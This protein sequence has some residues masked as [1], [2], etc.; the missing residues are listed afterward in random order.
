MGRGGNEYIPKAYL[1]QT[2]DKKKVILE[3]R[4]IFGNLHSE[5]TGEPVKTVLHKDQV[6]ESWVK[7][8]QTILIKKWYKSG[9]LKEEGYYLNDQLHRA[10]GPALR[11]WR[12]DGQ[13]KLEAFYLY[14]EIADNQD[15]LRKWNKKGREKDSSKHSK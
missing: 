8:G 15:S 3:Q 1:N 13:L 7:I 2:T 5:L 14:G 11:K 4:D 10:N 9:E 12:K 6:I